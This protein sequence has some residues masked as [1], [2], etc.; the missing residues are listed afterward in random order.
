V[1]QENDSEDAFRSLCEHTPPVVVLGG[2]S[3]GTLFASRIAKISPVLLVSD[4]RENVSAI[5]S[6]GIQVYS[7]QSE[8]DDTPSEGMRAT[9]NLFA[10]SYD[11]ALQKCR[12]FA[13]LVYVLTSGSH[14][15]HAAHLANE[16]VANDGIVV[17][18]Q[19]GYHS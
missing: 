10:L 1:V 11:D 13:K 4:H 15:A 8:I 3:M 5:R 17:T 16:I 18:L 12:K 9:Q 7:N 2:G 6:L 14:T 19:N